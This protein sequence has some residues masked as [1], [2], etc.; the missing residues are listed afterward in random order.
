[1]RHVWQMKQYEHSSQG[2]RS[3]SNVANKQTNHA[4]YSCSMLCCQELS[5]DH[6]CLRF[7]D[8]IFRLLNTPLLFDV[9]D[10]GDPL[11]LSGSY[12]VWEN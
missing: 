12:L 8:R 6:E 1:M 4:T 7:I 5:T 10:E 11:E 9:L 3:R 2:Q